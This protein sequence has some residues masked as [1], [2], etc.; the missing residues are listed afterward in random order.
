VSERRGRPRDTAAR[1]R[2]LVAAERQLV[3]D[4]YATMTMSGMAKEAGVAVQT[5]YLAYG[6]KVGVVSAVH[7]RTLAGDDATVPLLERGWM[8]QLAS[9]PTVL[10]AWASAMEHLSSTTVGVAPVHTAIQAASADPEMG[11]LLSDLRAQ[12][13]E[14]SRELATRLLA[15]PHARGGGVADRVADVLYALV[16]PE[17]H[18]LF[19][20]QRGWSV[21]EWRGWVHDAVLD[22]LTGS[23]GPAVPSP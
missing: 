10:E 15:L 8:R 2:I 14:F 21:E 3:S 17:T 9:A 6:S 19:V 12:R 20:I 18:D 22:E 11:A 5:L 13:H 7:D 4:G 1:R 23:R 16:G